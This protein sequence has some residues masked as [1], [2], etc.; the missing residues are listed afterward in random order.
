MFYGLS[1][2]GKHF[3]YIHYTLYDKVLW[4]ERVG[5]MDGQTDTWLFHIKVFY[6]RINHT[7]VF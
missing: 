7:D 1:L 6:S 3:F 4:T 5:G 2:E